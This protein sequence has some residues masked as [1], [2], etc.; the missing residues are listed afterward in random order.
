[1][2]PT[3]SLCTLSAC[4][5]IALGYYLGWA[6]EQADRWFEQYMDGRSEVFWMPEL[7]R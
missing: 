3:I 4:I 7:W 5:G 2:H 1:M 6:M